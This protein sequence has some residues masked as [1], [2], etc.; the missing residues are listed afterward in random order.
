MEFDHDYTFKRKITWSETL[1]ILWIARDF[2]SGPVAMEFWWDFEEYMKKK[3]RG[4]KRPRTFLTGK[5]LQTEKGS[6]KTGKSSKNHSQD[7]ENGFLAKLRD[8]FTYS[9]CFHRS[10][11]DLREHVLKHRQMHVWVGKWDEDVTSLRTA[12]YT[13]E[14]H[15][16]ENKN[17]FSGLRII[18]AYRITCSL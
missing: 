12:L 16:W 1:M 10:C 15:Y 13:L 6:W 2:N 7:L 17:A 9:M 4:R 14:I 11:C 5:I 18:T 8:S 3:G